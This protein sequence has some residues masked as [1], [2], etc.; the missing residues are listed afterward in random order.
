[1]SLLRSSISTVALLL[2]VGRFAGAEEPR[3]D[4]HGDPLP[5]G[6]LVRLGT[7]RFRPGGWAAGV[8]G[9]LPDGRTLV[10]STDGN[11]PLQFWD[12][13]SGKLLRVLDLGEIQGTGLSLSA[14]CRFAVMGGYL[15]GDGD[16]P[17]RSVIRIWDLVLG[18]EVRTFPRDA[19]DA[20]ASLAFTP[21]GKFLLLYNS[22]TGKLRILDAAS[23]L[24]IAQQQLPDGVRG[25]L[26]VSADGGTIAVGAGATGTGDKLFL[27]KW[28]EGA[29]PRLVQ[30]PRNSGSTLTFSPDGKHLAECNLSDN[31]FRLWDV[32]GG[33]VLHTLRTAETESAT[34]ATFS[35]D[36]KTLFT[37]CRNPR[38]YWTGVIHL[39]DTATGKHRDRLETGLGGLALSPDS[40]LLAVGRGG[41][42]QVWDLATRKELPH[43]EEAHETA[44]AHLASAGDL[45]ATAGDDRTIRLW[46][47][48]SA[49]QRLRLTHGHWVRGI[50]LSPDGKR[51][52]SSSLDDT[53]CLWDTTTGR[54]IFSLPGH[55]KSG[56]RRPVA[57]TPDGKHFLSW[58][59]DLYLRKW[60]VATGKAVLEHALQPTGVKVPDPEADRGERM[61]AVEQ[62]GAGAFS[63][64]GT[65]LVLH[66][67]NDF[68]VFDT[69]TGKDLRQ[70]PNEGGWVS[71]VAVSP[72]GTALLASAWGKSRQIKLPDGRIG[73][74]MQKDC[75]IGLWNLATGK[76]RNKVVLPDGGV[77]PVAFSADGKLFAA[78]TGR[79]DPR[80]RLWDTATGEERPSLTGFRG[81]VRSLAFLAD[82]QRLVSGMDDTTALI[83]NLKDKRK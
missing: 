52:V 38:E 54:K 5:P 63:P 26:A 32:A 47:A 49:K 9:F 1:M 10:T 66:V 79:P 30:A 45:L 41:R 57:F 59:E 13:T 2:A 74:T 39:W 55:G 51:L 46:D 71:S 58:G 75:P 80:I 17:G 61:L 18:K 78:A 12:V 56:G 73:F 76:L 34:W 67:W 72:D 28:Q 50:A 53:L 6:V 48:R 8:R 35:H 82:G 70:I 65:K 24:E 27:W 37:A 69:A 7:M 16:R 29:A 19:D 31:Q 77:G 43:I 11:M 33:R 4:R 36:G 40:R 23:G 21:D 83:W 68:H 64:D 25:G 14:N 20:L 3:V 42:V 60:D 22:Y 15:P 44:V 62:F 81:S